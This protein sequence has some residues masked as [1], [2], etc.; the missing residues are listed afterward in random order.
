MC[1]VVVMVVTHAVVLIG[2][3]WSVPVDAFGLGCVLLELWTGTP[4][5]PIT[6]T[7]A[8]RMTAVD[9]TAGP[10]S[11]RLARLAGD[12]FSSIFVVEGS[13]VRVVLTRKNVA[14]LSRYSRLRSLKHVS[15]STAVDQWAAAALISR[16]DRFWSEMN[17]TPN[18]ALVFCHLILQN[19]CRCLHS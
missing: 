9:R 11:A 18:C 8:E 4:A 14:G 12:C 7:V 15:V 16:D 1:V 5:F 6:D 3:A 17:S 19:E 2:L 10:I 13:D